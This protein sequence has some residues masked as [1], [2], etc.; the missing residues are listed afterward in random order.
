MKDSGPLVPQNVYIQ[1]VIRELNT[2]P[3]SPAHHNGRHNPYSKKMIASKDDYEEYVREYVYYR[4]CD[5]FLSEQYSRQLALETKELKKEADA[6]LKRQKERLEKHHSNEIFQIS[7]RHSIEIQTLYTQYRKTLFLWAR[8]GTS[9]VIV[10]LVAFF[11]FLGW[12]VPQKE[13]DAHQNGESSG[14]KSGYEA[15]LEEGREAGIESGY[16]RGYSDAERDEHINGRIPS[17]GSS[18]S[19]GSRSEPLQ[20]WITEPKSWASLDRIVYVSERS[21]TIHLNSGCSG[22]RNYFSMA[23]GDACAAGYAHCRTCF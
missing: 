21:H 5:R 15:G 7:K 23:Y 20:P 9:A 22:M 18:S 6:R 19:P 10:L 1:A 13:T 17:S 14:Y 2:V 8:R 12:Y 4:L 3:Y 16:Q 11:S